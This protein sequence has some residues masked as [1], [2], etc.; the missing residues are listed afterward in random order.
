MI[1][2]SC[3]RSVYDSLLNAKS[4]IFYRAVYYLPLFFSLIICN[5]LFHNVTLII[6]LDVYNQL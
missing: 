3:A 1:G 5:F 6:Y 4:R 2:R